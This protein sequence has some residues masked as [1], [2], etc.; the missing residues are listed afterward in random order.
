MRNGNPFST[1]KAADLSSGVLPEALRRQ[2]APD[3]QVLWHDS[4]RQGLMLRPADAVLIPFSLLW[5]GF[6]IAW[7]INALSMDMPLI[8][9]LWGIP[10]VLVGLYLIAGRFW[11]DARL[12]AHTHYALTNERILVV[13]GFNGQK[14]Q[15]HPLRTL[16]PITQ[17]ERADGSGTIA[18]GSPA[19]IQLPSGWPGAAATPELHIK[20]NVQ[21]VF[22]S[23]LDAQRRQNM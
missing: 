7:E 12:R 14:V 4:P 10:F 20:T 13:S 9:K 6:A 3:E 1:S 11:W 19:L 17:T 2:L 22:R 8:F 18:L 23:I 5:G 16:P 15:S 21:Q